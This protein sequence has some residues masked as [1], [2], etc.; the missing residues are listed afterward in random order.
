MNGDSSFLGIFS[1]VRGWFS[2]AAS[3]FVLYGVLRFKY[4]AIIAK[5]IVIILSIVFAVL[6]AGRLFGPSI[7][8]VP[9]N[10]L[11]AFTPII[12]II[13]GAYFVIKRGGKGK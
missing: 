13:F 2:T 6:A 4:R 1:Q 7:I 3:L 11:S 8:T 12:A 10:I 9:L 5:R